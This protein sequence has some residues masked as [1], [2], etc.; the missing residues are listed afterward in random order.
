ME[1]ARETGSPVEACWCMSA[2]FL[3]GVLDKIPAP[4]RGAACICALC[5]AGAPVPGPGS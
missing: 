3:P 4:M 2:E 5:A 1:I